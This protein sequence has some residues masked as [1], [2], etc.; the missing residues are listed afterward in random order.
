MNSFES[1]LPGT[2]FGGFCFMGFGTIATMSVSLRK[3]PKRILRSPFL[4]A[5]AHR[6][7]WNSFVRDKVGRVGKIYVEKL[8]KCTLEKNMWLMSQNL[9]P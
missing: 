5:P 9:S 7:L 1:H 3:K 6:N 4:W 2:F 8:S